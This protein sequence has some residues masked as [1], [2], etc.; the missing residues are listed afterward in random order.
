MDNFVNL[1][2]AATSWWGPIEFSKNCHK[3]A[4]NDG[5]AVAKNIT[6][7]VWRTDKYFVWGA[8]LRRLPPLKSLGVR[9]NAS[10]PGAAIPLRGGRYRWAQRFSSK[11]KSLLQAGQKVPAIKEIIVVLHVAHLCPFIKVCQPS[12][13]FNHKGKN[14]GICWIA[15]AGQ[16]LSKENSSFQFGLWSPRK[17]QVTWHFRLSRT[18]SVY[19]ILCMYTCIKNLF[20]FGIIFQC[21]ET[22]AFFRSQEKMSHFNSYTYTLVNSTT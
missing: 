3:G 13:M 10:C 8:F 18:T 1:K 9:M 21:S 14:K 16:K 6:T 11:H 7:L 2:G 17:T 20:A 19:S 5:N 12:N 22:P 4:M 15:N